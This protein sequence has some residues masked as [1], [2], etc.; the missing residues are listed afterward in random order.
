MKIVTIYEADDGTPFA[1]Y[2]DCEEYEIAI[3]DAIAATELLQQKASLYGALARFWEGGSSVQLN[4]HSLTSEQLYML[5]S[6]NKNT[7]IM[8]G[9]ADRSIYRATKI[10]H[11]GKIIVTDI[12][13]DI[14]KTI[15]I[16]ELANALRESTHLNNSNI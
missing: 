14:E 6:S 13:T 8:V 7:K 15:S 1:S 2:G 16:N 10:D 11:R 3:R 12:D 5:H 4:S 9:R